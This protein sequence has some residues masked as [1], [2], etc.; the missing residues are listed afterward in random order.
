MKT[1]VL[2]RARFERATYSS[3]GFSSVIFGDLRQRS[4]GLRKVIY[5]GHIQGISHEFKIWLR[6]DWTVW[7]GSRQHVAIANALQ[8]FE[9]EEPDF[10]SCAII[11]ISTTK[12][13]RASCGFDRLNSHNDA[14]VV[15]A[16]SVYA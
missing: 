8:Q 5:S 2:P 1:I 4:A 16:L 14:F 3:G 6:R 7:I 11:A 12:K 10:S 13:A 9:S 15:A